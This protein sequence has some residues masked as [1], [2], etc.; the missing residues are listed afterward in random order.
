MLACAIVIGGAFW[1]YIRFTL[2]G[3]AL[4][5]SGENSVGARIVGIDTRHY[6]RL[7][8]V[9]TAVIAAVFGIVESPITGS[10]TCRARRSR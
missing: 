10:P 9:G 4:E 3:K 8:F 7:I 5:A 1:L 2:G 6:R